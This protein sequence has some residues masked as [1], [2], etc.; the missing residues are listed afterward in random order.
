[1]L[2]KIKRG[3]LLPSPYDRLIFCS[4]GVPHFDEDAGYPTIK[5]EAAPTY[6]KELCFMKVFYKQYCRIDI[7]KNRIISC[8][9]RSIRKK[10]IR[11]FS[12]MTEDI[13]QLVSWLKEIGCKMTAMKSTGSY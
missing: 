9:F 8:V 12:I 1:M 10:Q 3:L 5:Q 4:L 7:H 2:N 11:Q 13:I 6:A